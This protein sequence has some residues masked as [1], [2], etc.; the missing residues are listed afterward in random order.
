MFVYLVLCVCACVCV[1]V[2]H[3]G[4]EV[5][6]ED[7]P[8]HRAISGVG[9]GRIPVEEGLELVSVLA[10]TVSVSH[11]HTHTHTHKRTHKHAQAQTHELP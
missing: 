1:C 3:L 4:S 8:I 6:V 10:D 2:S 7:S 5:S 9:S 11:T